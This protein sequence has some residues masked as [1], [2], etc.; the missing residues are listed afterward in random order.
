MKAPITITSADPILK[1]LRFKPHRSNVRR[2]V[3]RFLPASGGPQTVD[4]KTPWGE[5]LTAKPGDYLVSEMD[6]PND[7]WPV[8]SGIF[9]QT[10][11]II[12]PGICIKRA[13]TD[14]IPLTELTGGDPEQMVTVHSLEGAE[15]VCAGEFYLA[16]GVKGEIWTY[17]NHKVHKNMI[18]VE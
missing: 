2:R 6:S 16:R 7:A 17:P 10:Y 9:E 1:K 5:V 15:T 12:E 13:L 3:V 8:D 11:E 18:P 14:L 4:L